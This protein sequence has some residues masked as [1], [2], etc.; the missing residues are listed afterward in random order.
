MGNPFKAV[1]PM[2]KTIF[3]MA[4]NTLVGS[5]KEPT[6]DNLLLMYGFYVGRA[7][8]QANTVEKEEHATPNVSAL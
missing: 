7:Y 3:L 8:E 4:Y 2:R 1:H 5:G 6:M